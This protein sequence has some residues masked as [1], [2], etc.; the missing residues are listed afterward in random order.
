MMKIV[1]LFFI[2][3]SIVGLL[4]VF[5]KENNNVTI[6]FSLDSNGNYTGF[7]NLPKNY[8]VEDAKKDGYFVKQDS[9][10]IANNEVWVNFVETARQGNNNAG[11]RIVSFYSENIASPYFIDLFFNDGYF[12]LFDSSSDI[13]DMQPVSYLLTLEGQ[14]GHS[15]DI[16][17]NT[18]VVL[19]SI[20]LLCFYKQLEFMK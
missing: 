9:E 10:V 14:F 4:T 19:H 7:S 6:A 18:M 20:N 11:I 3:L 5:N 16:R 12:Y 13:Q 15:K 17:A 2:V 8:T 1:V